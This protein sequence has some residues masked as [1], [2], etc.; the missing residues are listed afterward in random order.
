MMT[1]LWNKDG[2]LTQKYKNKN[3]YFKIETLKTQGGQN[4]SLRLQI[5]CM[6]FINALN[7]I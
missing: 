5:K 4:K 3:N 2:H 6:V 7:P 1:S